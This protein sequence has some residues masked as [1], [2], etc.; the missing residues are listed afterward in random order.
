M[1]HRAA[2]CIYVECRCAEARVPQRGHERGF[3][4]RRTARDVDQRAARTQRFEHGFADHM[5]GCR[6]TTR[7]RCCWDI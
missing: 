4:D 5:P 6:V 3:V 7:S 2:P 1:R